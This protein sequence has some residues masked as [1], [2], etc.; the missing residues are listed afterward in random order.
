MAV[1]KPDTVVASVDSAR[2]SAIRS[3]L[4]SDRRRHRNDSLRLAEAPA[5]PTALGDTLA[6]DTLGMPVDTA[7]T[8][9]ARKEKKPFLEDIADFSA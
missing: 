6:A 2:R 3:V 1:T 9:T 7:A 5:S 8:D 4:P